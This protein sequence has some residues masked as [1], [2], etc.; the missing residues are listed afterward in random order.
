[1]PEGILLPDYALQPDG[2]S[3]SERQGVREVPVLEGE[4]LETMRMA[5]KLGREARV[6]GRTVFWGV[7]WWL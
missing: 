5:C 3:L 4:E 1:M 2:S 7:G 6:W